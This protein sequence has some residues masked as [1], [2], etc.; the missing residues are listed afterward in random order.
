M[1]IKKMFGNT[2]IRKRDNVA[3]HKVDITGIKTTNLNVLKNDE[4]VNLLFEYRDNKSNALLEKII[5]G[6]L[7]LVLSVIKNF[8]NRCDNQ[9]DLFQI[10]IVGL[11]KAI[12][13]FDSQYNLKFS[14]YAVP[15]IIGEIKR[16]LRDNT[17]VRISRQIKDL[18]YKSLKAK[19]EYIKEHNIEPS[20]EVL[21]N[22]LSVSI[23]ELQEALNSTQSVVSIYET[24][25]GE[26]DESIQLIDQ[27]S[28]ESQSSEKIINYITLKYALNKLSDEQKNI[29]RDRYYF[30]KTQF[31]IANEFNISQAQVSRIE[32]AAIDSLRSYF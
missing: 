23:N 21:S 32:K 16:Y 20:L 25:Y 2:L 5:L 1:N 14:T 15:M 7:K 8:N 26:G 9:D 13:N 28:D 24:V 17:P 12:N 11:I 29:I 10:G 31:E 6:N 18:A 27:I 4:T 22:I 19:E 30:G 3:K